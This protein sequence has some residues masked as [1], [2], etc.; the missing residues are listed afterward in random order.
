MRAG[1][2]RRS[3]KLRN[4]LLTWILAS[5]LAQ[6]SDF[7]SKLTVSGIVEDLACILVAT[8]CGAAGTWATDAVFDTT[9]QEALTFKKILLLIVSLFAEG[10]QPNTVSV[11][12]T[13]FILY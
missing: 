8:E 11:I 6:G 12:I 10:E 9:G 7:A 4:N 5:L 3:R 13:N 2:S 1:W